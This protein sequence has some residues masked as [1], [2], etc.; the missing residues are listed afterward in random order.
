MVMKTAVLAVLVAADAGLSP[1]EIAITFNTDEKA[2]RNHLENLEDSGHVECVEG[3]YFP[4]DGAR[5]TITYRST[6]ASVD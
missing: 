1:D 3:V 4:T 6:A 5:P 2:V